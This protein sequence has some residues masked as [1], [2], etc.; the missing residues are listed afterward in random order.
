MPM[1]SGPPSGMFG[2][3]AAN[4]A[5]AQAAAAR[6]AEARATAAAAAVDEAGSGMVQDSVTGEMRPAAAQGRVQR[7]DGG[8]EGDLWRGME[9]MG[10]SGG[11]Q[12]Q[13]RGPYF[14]AV[15]NPYYDQMLRSRGPLGA[16]RPGRNPGGLAA[17]QSGYGGASNAA[18]MS[19]LGG[20]GGSGHPA[21]RGMGPMGMSGRPD[22]GQ[23]AGPGGSM[24]EQLLMQAR[25]QQ[26][27]A[28]E[29]MGQGAMS[30]PRP[31]QGAGGGGNR[32]WNHFFQGR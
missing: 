5:N 16:M 29:A 7:L 28:M 32:E 24:A 20:G 18:S 19:D 6:A 2:A 22:Q 21:M 27:M 12:A 9:G 30:E 23:G 13:G 11:Y 1:P 15:A 17:A 4:S 14:G 25:M 26:R 3:G 8:D 31:Q 10:I